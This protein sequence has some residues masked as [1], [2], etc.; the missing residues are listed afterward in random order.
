MAMPEATTSPLTTRGV[1]VGAY[2]TSN[3]KFGEGAFRTFV[4]PWRYTGLE[5]VRELL[6]DPVPVY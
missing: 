2:A 6:E 4:S 5:Q 3:G 1:V